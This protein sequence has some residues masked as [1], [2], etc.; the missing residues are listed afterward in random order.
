MKLVTH[1]RNLLPKD[2]VAILIEGF[3]SDDIAKRLLKK[4]LTETAWKQES[5]KILVN[6]DSSRD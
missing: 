2:G 4:L 6:G 5:V 1:A 3:Y